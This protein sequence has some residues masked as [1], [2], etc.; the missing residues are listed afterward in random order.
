MSLIPQKQF[1]VNPNGQL[2][3]FSQELDGSGAGVYPEMVEAVFPE[4]G[5][6]S[7]YLYCFEGE[8]SNEYEM[9]SWMIPAATGDLL[10]VESSPDS[11]V[12]GA[13][14]AIGIR[15][16][17]ATLGQGPAYYHIGKY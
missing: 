4:N 7:V 3:A 5:I 15:W 11:A 13:T 1:L 2:V 9:L 8:T 12:A 6:W 14:E 10:E 16:T 17:G